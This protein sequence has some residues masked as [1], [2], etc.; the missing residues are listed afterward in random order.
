MDDPKNERA[1]ED[2]SGGHQSE[3][4]HH[5]D[6]ERLREGGGEP[7]LDREGEAAEDYAAEEGTYALDPEA[8][9]EGTPGERAQ[10]LAEKEDDPSRRRGER[11]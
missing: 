11:S 9:P 10:D 7:L 6:R 4:K 3:R 5:Q 2:G 1:P 8:R